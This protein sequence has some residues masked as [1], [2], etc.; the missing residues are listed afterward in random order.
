MLR[1]WSSLVMPSHFRSYA[2][3]LLCSNNRFVLLLSCS[4][5]CLVMIVPTSEWHASAHMTYI[6]KYRYHLRPPYAALCSELQNIRT[7]TVKTLSK[8]QIV[9][10]SVSSTTTAEEL[11]HAH[12]TRMPSW[13]HHQKNFERNHRSW[14]VLGVSMGEKQHRRVFLVSTEIMHIR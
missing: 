6:D 3:A 13:T 11:Q 8:T 4:L 9:M 1:F 5:D 2:L 14:A 12:P 10:K 7:L